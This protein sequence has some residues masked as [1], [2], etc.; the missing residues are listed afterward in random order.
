MTTGRAHWP[1]RAIADATRLAVLKGVASVSEQGRKLAP[2]LEGARVRAGHRIE[3][4]RH[5]PENLASFQRWYADPDIAAM[6]RHDLS[7]LDARQSRSYFETLILP[8]SARGFCWAIVEGSESRLL[9]TTALTEVS[10][11]DQSA[12]FRIVIGER[13]TWGRGYGTEA[14]RLVCE[15]AFS[16]LGLSGIRLEVFDH[17]ERAIG[18]YDRVGFRQTGEHVEFVR[19]RGIDLHVREM[20]LERDD[21]LRRGV[22]ASRIPVYPPEGTDGA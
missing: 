1:Q 18:A 20:R 13:D 3:L 14:T 9:G 21:Y 5:V 22:F 6:L 15:E 12:L 2:N 4:R 17:N 10:N 8:L 16:G 11:R 19:N 7:P